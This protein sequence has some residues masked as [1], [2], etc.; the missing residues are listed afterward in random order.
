M[1][2]K[3]LWIGNLFVYVIQNP[4]IFKRVVP[5]AEDTNSVFRNKAAV[6][7]KTIR[8]GSKPSFISRPFPN[9]FST[10]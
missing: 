2:Q 7:Q 10:L 4:Q 9:M 1:K 3:R 8:W 5:Y 6:P